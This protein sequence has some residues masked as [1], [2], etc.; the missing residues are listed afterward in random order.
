MVHHGTA[1]THKRALFRRCGGIMRAQRHMRCGTRASH[2]RSNAAPTVLVQRCRDRAR[3]Q[4]A[5]RVYVNGVTNGINHNENVIVAAEEWCA[6]HQVAVWLARAAN[7]CPLVC[8]R[9]QGNHQFILSN[10]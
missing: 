5:G 3:N 6:H 10:L 8:V 2:R 9:L 4:H 1:H 7:Q